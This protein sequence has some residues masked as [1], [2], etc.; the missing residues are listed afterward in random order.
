MPQ[1]EVSLV[2]KL[3]PRYGRA[4]SANPLIRHV[5]SVTANVSGDDKQAS[6]ADAKKRILKWL[7]A[8]VGTLPPEAWEGKTFEHMSPGRFAAGVSIDFDEGEYWAVRCDDP[9]KSVPG[10]TW[11]TEASLAR[12]GEHSRFG[13]RLLFATTEV[14]PNYSP[15]IPGIVR[16]LCES[17]GLTRN[18]RVLSP[19]PTLVDTDEK[20]DFFVDLLLDPRR[21]NP[22]F[23]ISLDEQEI[24]AAT[25]AIDPDN[26]AAR[27]LGIAHTVVVTG[28]QAFRLSDVLGKSFSV[29]RGAV[30][31][32]R[33]GMTYDDDPYRHPFATR[34]QIRDWQ[35]VGP[36]AFSNTLIW[37]AARNS[38]VSNDE[39][40]D[41]PPFTKAKQIA[42]QTQRQSARDDSDY[43]ALLALADNELNEKQR[44]IAAL[45]AMLVEEER[46]REEADCRA[47]DLNASNSFL[48]HR[49]LELE[50]RLTFDTNEQPVHYPQSYP[51]IPDWVDKT[52]PGRICLT[53]RARR[54]M[55]DAEFADVE[56]VGRCLAYLATEFWSMKT[57]GG[58]D[59]VQNNE[60][61]LGELSVKNEPSGAEHLL[62]EQ[63]D[64]FYVKWGASGNKRLLDMHLKNGGNTRDPSRCFRIYY[65]WDD[66]TQQVVVGSLPAHL[67]SRAS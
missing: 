21:R 20:L 52:Y 46:K 10:R 9:D 27:C 35:G 13:L 42:L 38:A 26:L 15:S 14:E 1:I 53:A 55:K 30:R 28:P 6:L 54:E 25:A 31:T 16:H 23:A 22:V 47:N 61:V 40:R 57:Q 65:F 11:T 51:E 33:A 2:E 18:G 37:T 41:L 60:R 44:E 39:A 17:P 56:L 62:K 58:M 34:S 32:Y 19:I 29:F 49:V 45:E 67:T 24:N 4:Q 7:S 36:A 64:T 48:R 66:E 3:R 8:R 5:V 63:G 50:A 59:F 12:R 43:P